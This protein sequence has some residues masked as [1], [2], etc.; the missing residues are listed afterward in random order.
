MALSK[1]ERGGAPVRRTL[2][3]Q[4]QQ[5][6]G[7][8]LNTTVVCEL[9]YVPDEGQQVHTMV[10]G[11]G[12]R[13]DSRQTRLQ[14]SPT[15]DDNN[16][17]ENAQASQE[18]EA[19]LEG[20]ADD[21]ESSGSQTQTFS[22]ST[23]R[24][25]T[26]SRTRSSCTTLLPLTSETR[27]PRSYPSSRMSPQTRWRQQQL[28]QTSSHPGTDSDVSSA[29]SFAPQPSSSTQD[30]QSLSAQ[31]G[32]SSSESTLPECQST[33]T[34]LRTQETSLTPTTPHGSGDGPGYLPITSPQSVAARA[35]KQ[36]L[37]AAKAMGKTTVS[38][39]ASPTDRT[40]M[41]KRHV[42]SPKTK[43]SS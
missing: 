28:Y 2:F 10:K 20:L 37:K 8:W 23:V 18:E 9:R 15:E 14:Y 22:A 4:S 39:A 7:G 26:P 1:E 31:Q 43:D 12:R 42:S 21:P 6:A 33:P 29:R 3:S 19:W 16:Q 5:I 11:Y 32:S 35:G 41:Q 36:P 40:S 17:Q 13:S 34:S 27:S 24:P 38:S 30:H 25:T